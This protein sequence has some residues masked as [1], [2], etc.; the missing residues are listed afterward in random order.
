MRRGHVFKRC[1]KCGSRVA[2]QKCGRCGAETYTWVYKVDDS[3]PGQARH[4]RMKGGF[5]T[6]AAALGALSKL[7]VAKADGTHVDP[8][9][10][11][12]G[13]YLDQWWADADAHGWEGT[14]KTEYG[15]SIRLH[16]KPHLGST[17]LQTLTSAQV[18]A[19]YAWLLKSGK[20]RRD[21]MGEI[22][23][24]GPLSPK[25]VQNIHIVLRSALNDAVNADPPL[26]RRNVAMGCYTYSRRK[27][28]PE[29]LTLTIEEV[30]AFLVRTVDDPQHVLWRVAL[31]T[32]LRRGELLGLRR[33]DL[34]L[35]KVVNGSA[36]PALNV[37]QQYARNGEAGLTFR[38]LKT[39][40]MAWRAV[41]LDPETAGALR[42]H[43]EAQDTQR[44]VWGDAYAGKCPRCGKPI[45]DRCARCGRPAADLDL[46]FCHPEGTPYD[47]DGVTD[48][49]ERAT[50]QCPGVLRI[51]FHDMRHTHAT[52]LLENGATER[53]VAERLGDTV[54]MVH[55]TYGHVTAKMRAGAVELLSTLVT[56]A[57]KGRSG[58]TQISDESAARRVPWL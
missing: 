41:D 54:E 9:R 29:M 10:L 4:Q 3:L 15:V 27:R 17:P 35:D 7:Q 2:E 47:P 42:A 6:K 20:V 26:V 12:L 31:M 14:T 38:G 25:T 8:T 33:R 19:H 53:Y 52:L 58:S 21:R 1:T 30:R 23:Y 36:A 34:V 32:G 43:V 56:G 57:T 50:D 55:E 44:A 22:T 28:R 46:V 5:S 48:R 16:L 51:R 13:E 39:G 49:F 37:R 40:T 45:A 24:Q 11:T 18:R